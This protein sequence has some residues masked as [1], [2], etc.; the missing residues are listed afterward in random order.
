MITRLGTKKEGMLYIL[1]IFN[2]FKYKEIMERV[3]SDL[4]GNSIWTLAKVNIN[5]MNENRTSYKSM[6]LLYIVKAPLSATQVLLTQEK[7]DFLFSTQIINSYF[8]LK[9]YILFV[10]LQ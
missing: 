3:I 5:F 7:K 1:P 2:K 9:S 6:R 8:F 10:Q 4:Q